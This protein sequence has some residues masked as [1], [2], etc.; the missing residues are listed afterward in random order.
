MDV[1]PVP[2]LE[3]MKQV[4]KELKRRFEHRLSKLPENIQKEIK[5]KKGDEMVKLANKWFEKLGIPENR[6]PI[7]GTFTID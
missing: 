7:C 5:E 1:T 2:F 4:R 6:E 3:Y